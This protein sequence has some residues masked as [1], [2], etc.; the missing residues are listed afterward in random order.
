MA[1]RDADAFNLPPNYFDTTF[2]YMVC[3][4]DFMRARRR[5]FP[6]SK[7]TFT[8]NSADDFRIEQ[9]TRGEWMRVQES[10]ALQTF[11][12]DKIDPVQPTVLMF[13]M[14][15]EYLEDD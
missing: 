2:T 15:V 12:Y 8:P 5:R 4:G 9:T 10:T 3:C 13:S 14:E 1:S 7:Q 11:Y 6:R